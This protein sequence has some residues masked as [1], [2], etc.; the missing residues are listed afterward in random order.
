MPGEKSRS[1]GNI[2]TLA[3]G[4][5]QARYRGPDGRLRSAPATFA[6]KK[7]AQ[8]WLTLKEAEIARGDWFD[9]DAGALLFHDY[10]VEWMEQRDLTRKT[11]ST[12]EVLIR[13]HL[14]PTFGDMLLRDINEAHV[15]KWRSE[16]LKMKKAR[17]QVP[18]A[19]RLL[20]AILNT[21]VRDK[22]IRENPCQIAG[23]GKE[24]TE[25][26]PVLSVAEVFKLADAIKPRYRALVLLATFGSLRWGELAGLRRR[27][28]DLDARTVTVRETAD[29]VGDIRVGKPKSKAG[30]RTVVLP[31]LIIEDLRHHIRDYAAPGSDGF[32]FVGAKGNQLRRSN[33]SKYWADACAAVGLKGV[34][35]HDLRHTGNTYAAETGA[36]LR[37]LMNRMGHSSTRAALIYMHARDERA[38]AIADALGQRAADELKRARNT[39][40]GGDG[41]GA[42]S[43]DAGR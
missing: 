31:E 22:L 36:S 18:K 10:A 35:V 21:A 15:R 20:R 3:S 1:F 24:D 16:R 25:E 30:A 7:A 39:D 34:H 23:A 33:F 13:R 28:L 11:E 12:Y 9:P 32:V 38:R 5:F 42:P 8:R 27:Y 17:S 29:D 4:R 37:E 14:D 2:R 41:Q 19:Y 40:D 26:R 6:A 43:A